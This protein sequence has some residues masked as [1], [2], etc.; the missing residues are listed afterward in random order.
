MRQ[1]RR[2]VILLTTHAQAPSRRRSHALREPFLTRIDGKNDRKYPL[3]GMKMCQKFRILSVGGMRRG[4]SICGQSHPA[5]LIN[6]RPGA[7]TRNQA[8]DKTSPFIHPRHLQWGGGL[9]TFGIKT[10]QAGLPIIQAKGACPARTASCQCPVVRPPRARVQLERSS[11]R[12]RR[13]SR[14]LVMEAMRPHSP[15]LPA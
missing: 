5:F 8:L 10:P 13:A 11:A 7:S 4:C 2:N 14:A 1:G 6:F 15:R 3:T 9:F 12:G